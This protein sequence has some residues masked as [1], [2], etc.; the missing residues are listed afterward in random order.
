MHDDAFSTPLPKTKCGKKENFSECFL[1]TCRI[2]AVGLDKRDF[3]LFA[4]FKE[5]VED[6]LQSGHR[7]VRRHRVVSLVA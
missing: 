6:L 3:D 2:R 1:T 5:A 4:D 7:S